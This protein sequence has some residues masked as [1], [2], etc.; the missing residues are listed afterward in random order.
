[1]GKGWYSVRLE[2][3]ILEALTYVNWTSSETLPFIL[4]VLRKTWGFG[5][6]K[7]WTFS[8]ESTESD[9]G[10]LAM[11]PPDIK[12]RTARRA[13]EEARAR[14]IVV[15]VRESGKKSTYGF[16]KHYDTWIYGKKLSDEYKYTQ[17][18]TSDTGDTGDTEVSSDIHDS[19][20]TE[21]STMKPLNP[22][23]YYRKLK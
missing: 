16:N 12:T 22:E 9:R 3:H 13:V 10:I 4:I 20:D 7:S 14:N 11:L 18:P 17:I 19:G 6:K 8:Y 21:V 15:V 1:V 23:N 2:V 5:N